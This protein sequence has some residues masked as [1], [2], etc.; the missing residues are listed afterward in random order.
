MS[1]VLKQLADYFRGAMEEMRKVTW[2]TKQQTIN[3]SLVVVGMSI[4]VAV[5]F[6]ILDY[7]LNLGLE[8]IIR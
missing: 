5:F 8:Q 4:G 7:V 1:N 3:Y 2:P 6:G